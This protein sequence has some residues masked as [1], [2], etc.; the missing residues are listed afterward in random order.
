MAARAVVACHLSVGIGVRVWVVGFDMGKLWMIF[1]AGLTEYHRHGVEIVFSLV[2]T[3]ERAFPLG[4]CL[5]NV[6]PAP[7]R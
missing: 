6:A 3:V 7:E 1:V 2:L 5:F 4:K